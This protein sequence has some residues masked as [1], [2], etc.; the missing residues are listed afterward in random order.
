MLKKPW[1]IQ[2]ENG[3][4]VT[5]SPNEDVFFMDSIRCTSIAVHLRPK[6]AD[7]SWA[8]PAINIHVRATR[9]EVEE[10]NEPRNDPDDEY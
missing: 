5:F 2:T 3:D 9:Y 10:R 6:D 8:C 1:T 7:Y 4:T